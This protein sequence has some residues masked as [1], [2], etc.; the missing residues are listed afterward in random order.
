MSKPTSRLPFIEIIEWEAHDPNLL[1]WKTP[2]GDREIKN[3]AKLI[4]RDSQLAMLISEGQLAGVFK[5]G[6]HTLHTQN[7]PILTRLKGWKYGFESPF[8]IDVYFFSNK[9]FVNLKWGTPSPIILRDPQFGQVRIRA[10]GTYNVR[11]TDVDLF[12]KEY[13]GNREQ[14]DITEFEKKLRDFIAPKFG[15]ALALSKIATLDISQNLSALNARIQPLI[16][17]YFE[18]FGVEITQ[19]TVTAVN[20][21]EE[22]ISYYDKVTGMNMVNNLENFQKFNTAIATSNEHS[23]IGEGA[24]QGLAMGMLLT[25]LNQTQEQQ[26][27]AY[28]STQENEDAIAD[29]LQKLKN[30]FDN[31]LIDESEYKA[32]KEVIL[33]EL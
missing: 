19:F 29:R 31:G 22:V 5:A 26:K 12:F 25:Q 1:M 6:T 8:K 32:K 11:V 7:I 17:P 9:Q 33:G 16:Q 13:A 28:T 30:L 3:G 14:L 24:Q 4:V 18:N 21:P 20:L 10:F 23:R 27:T 2:D 15:E